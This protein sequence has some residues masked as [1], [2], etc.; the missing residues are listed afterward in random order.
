MRRSR[1][2][3]SGLVAALLALSPLHSHAYPDGIS[4]A[5]GSPGSGDCTGCHSGGTYSYFAS[6]TPTGG[7]VV[8]RNTAVTMSFSV[9]RTGGVSAKDTGLN[10]ASPGGGTLSENSSLL[11]LMVGENGLNEITHVVP[12]PSNSLIVG[13]S[14]VGTGYVW[15]SFTWTSPNAS[16]SFTL[17]ACGNLVNG[18]RTNP[19]DGN[20]YLGDNPACTTLTMTVNNAPNIITTGT[21]SYTENA[22]AI[23]VHSTANITDTETDLMQ[24]AT[25]S[26]T[27]AQTGD[28]LNIN[29]ATCTAN[30]LTCSGSGGT[31]I[32]ISGGPESIVEFEAVMQAITYDNTSDNPSTTTRN[33]RFTINDTY[34]RSDFSNRSITFTAVN[35]A[36]VLGGVSATPTYVEGDNPGVIIDGAVTITDPDSANCNLATVDLSTN[37]QSG[38]DILEYTASLPAGIAMT[39]FDPVTGTLSFSGT[40]TCAAYE[41][42]LESVRYRNTSANPSVSSRTAVFQVRDSGNALSNAPSTTVAV[43]AVSTAPTISNVSGGVNYTEDATPGV[44]LDDDVAVSDPDSTD[45][46]EA[47]VGITGNYQ[48]GADV[49][50]YTGSVSG[51]SAAF[52]AASGQLTLS[53]TGS[54]ACADF[55]TALQNVRFRNTSQAPSVSL[56]TV[57]FIVSDSGNTPSNLVSK[58]VSV[59]ATDD[60]PGAVDDLMTV[61]VNSVDN[62]LAVLAND[63]DPDGD[64]LVLVS[65]SAPNNGGSTALGTG[66]PC[67]LNTVCYT[68]PADFTGINTFTYTVEDSNG[69]VAS[70]GTVTVQPPD[71]D[72]DGRIDFLDNC[73]AISNAGQENNDG[74]GQGDVCDDDDDN[75]GM[76]D[77]FENMYVADCGLDPFDPVDAAEDCDGDGLNNLGEAQADKDPTLDDV[78][79][80]FFGAQDITVDSTG[81]LTPVNLGNIRAVDGA[82]GAVPVSVVSVTGSTSQGSALNGLFRPGTTVIT[83]SAQDSQGNLIS[84]VQTIDVRPL[85]GFASDQVASEGGSAFI[86]VLLNGQAPQYPVT[87]NYTVS[88]TSGPSD[89]DAVNGTITI[90][91]AGTSGGI[92]VNFADDGP[93]DN[94]E[95]L[96]LTL[97]N[98]VNTALGARTRHTVRILEGN[99]P[100]RIAFLY[101]FQAGAGFGSQ[102]VADQGI[103]D[104]FVQA[105]A[106]DPNP[107]D[108]AALAYQWTTDLGDSTGETLNFSS[109]GLAPGMYP[110]RV[111]VTD[112]G[113]ASADAEI[114][115]KVLPDAPVLSPGVDADGDTADNDVEGYGDDDLDGI[116]NYLDAYSFSFADFS[117]LQNQVGDFNGAGQLQNIKLLQT[118]PGLLIR[119]GP[120]A[121]HGGASGALVSA[122]QVSDYAFFNGVNSS[123]DDRANIGGIFDFEIYNMQPGSTARVVLPLSARILG[124]SGFRKFSL[125]HGWRDFSTE[126]GN[127]IATARSTNGAC[128]AP[129]HASYRRGL[130][131]F[132]D[133]VQL[134]L[135]DGGPNDADGLE[136]GVIHDPGGV[137]VTDPSPDPEAP[138]AAADGSGGGL[139]HPLWLLLLLAW[140]IV[141]FY[142]PV[143]KAKNRA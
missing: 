23:V 130:N 59:T 46:L 141:R 18:N 33:V 74:D 103:D 22:A 99:V 35:D 39:P 98:P 41:T 129:G 139:M 142:V 27:N 95:T 87:L 20:G 68:P 16:N 24:S 132:D 65:V 100:P 55:G 117:V 118:E 69:G 92:S 120:V 108:A 2:G 61:A 73:P 113:G 94:N 128:P 137:A 123:A 34:S 15:P 19:L 1:Q 29:A 36:P 50:E 86:E 140:G 125:R 57:G 4:F 101:A 112:G 81:Y 143:R 43:Q 116:P 72:G 82:N 13:G 14:N 83:R 114:F 121:L 49:L 3:R 48:S 25:V 62:A 119:K 93:G 134:T 12:Q 76:P 37:Y 44:I 38:E 80:A 91:A 53:A 96:V 42:V 115:I 138:Q 31:T 78:A 109:N 54:V 67:T 45:C 30:Q 66:S 102:I 105:F 88:G 85:A 5:S 79:P 77:V 47:V 75:D 90:D 7:T 135:V 21:T 84:S 28:R 52:S 64:S 17:Y 104:V 126:G 89:H 111:R 71:T 107:G 106:V 122:A 11:Q 70:T 136:N 10:V 32:T 124:G 60:D 110:V 8:E 97:S 40:A 127:A 58:N 26:I 131:T 6:L 51:I 9:S 56:R 63:V 133:C